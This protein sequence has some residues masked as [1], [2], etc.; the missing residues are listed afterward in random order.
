MVYSVLPLGLKGSKFVID[1]AVSWVSADLASLSAVSFPYIFEW[2]G[3]HLTSR[4]R[5]V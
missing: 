2:L 1:S 4:S 3:I 5:Q